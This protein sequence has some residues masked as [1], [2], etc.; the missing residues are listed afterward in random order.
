MSNRA[1]SYGAKILFSISVR[2]WEKLLLQKTIF[3][4]LPPFPR[5]VQFAI[6]TGPFGAVI[7]MPVKAE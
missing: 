7:L 4:I 5:T 6:T 3:E 2:I 1:N